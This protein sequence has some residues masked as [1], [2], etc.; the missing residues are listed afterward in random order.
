M[1]KAVNRLIGILLCIF[2]I[3]CGENN[4]DPSLVNGKLVGSKWTTTNWDYGIGDDWASTIDETYNLFFY[5]STEG[6]IYYGRKDYD[7]DFGASSS[8]TVG[9]FN[10][11]IDGNKIELSYITSPI[12]GFYEF[13]LQGGYF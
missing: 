9:H 5:S 10:Y 11:R 12:S 6:L 7:S 13:E 4:D 1:N 2:F 3:S 8:R